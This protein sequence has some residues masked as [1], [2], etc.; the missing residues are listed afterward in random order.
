MISVS[1]VLLQK[2]N[3]TSR[4]FEA[5]LEDFSE[6]V[7]SFAISKGTFNFPFSPN[8]LTMGA[9]SSASISCDV[10]TDKLGK[11]QRVKLFVKI[12]G[13]NQTI[14]LGEYKIT[15][16]KKIP[17]SNEKIQRIVAY[18]KINFLAQK[19]YSS[20][21]KKTI[22]KVWEE[23]CLGSISTGFARAYKEYTGIFAN[24][25]ID[26]GLLSGYNTRDAMSFLA[27]CVGCNVVVNNVG[28]YELREV[29]FFD[30][31]KGLNF[32]RI[33]TPTIDESDITIDYI[34]AKKSNEET[35]SAGDTTGQ[36]LV[37]SNPVLTQ[38]ILN[39]VY[40]SIV[41][42][43]QAYRSGDINYVLADPTVECGDA[44]PLYDN[45]NKKISFVIANE[46]KYTFDGGLSCSI[47]SS[48]PN[49]NESLTLAEKINF[50]VKDSVDS[51]K[52]AQAAIDFSKAMSNGLGMHVSTRTDSTGA[53]IYYLHDK[54]DLEK[55]ERI[56]MVTSEG[57]G[58]A[59][60]WDGDF[61]TGVNAD[62]NIITNMLTVYKINA[63]MIDAGAI[64]STKIRG[65]AVTADKI[66]VED[67]SALNATI[68]NWTIHSNLLYVPSEKQS[69]ATYSYGIGLSNTVV[70]FYAGYLS[71]D[72]TY[73]PSASHPGSPYELGDFDTNKLNFYVTRAGRLVAR[74]AEIS[75][76]ITSVSSD[77]KGKIVIDNGGFECYS[78]PNEYSGLLR[79]GL[80]K[81][82]I[83][84][85]ISTTIPAMCIQSDY[86]NSSGIILSANKNAWQAI[87]NNE[88][89]EGIFSFWNKF[90]GSVKFQ[91]EIWVDG[92]VTTSWFYAAHGTSRYT[93]FRIANNGVLQIG[94]NNQPG[95]TQIY[96]NSASGFVASM[97]DFY[98]NKSKGI[99]FSD[100]TNYNRTFYF[101]TVNDLTGF[102]IGMDSQKNYFYGGGIYEGISGSPLLTIESDALVL[103]ERT[104]NRTRNKID[105]VA[106]TIR[107]R[108]NFLLTSGYKL[109]LYIDSQIYDCLKYGNVELT[110]GTYTG[111][112]FGLDSQPLNLWYTSAYLH[113][114]VSVSGDV[115]V[116]KYI[117]SN[118]AIVYGSIL[119]KVL[120]IYTSNGETYYNVVGFLSND[121]FQ[122]GSSSL[123]KRL[124]L[125]SG[126]EIYCL[127]DFQIAN[128]KSIKVS[129]G[130]TWNIAF[131][132]GADSI[133]K[134]T[135]LQVGVDG[136]NTVLWGT[137][138]LSS[139][140]TVTSDANQKNT[141]ETV[142]DNYEKLFYELKPVTYKYNYGTS[143]RKHLGFIAQDVKNAIDKSDLTT[144]DVAAY[145]SDLCEDGTELLSLR[146]EEFVAL[147][148]H[149]IQKC[150]A[151]ISSLEDEIKL[152][153][154]E[155]INNG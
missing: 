109:Q 82:D 80:V 129:D 20:T 115:N 8:G 21:G 40:N 153:K 86:I 110:S 79:Y 142:S 65:K 50:S 55:S 47:T 27:S 22:A 98:I 121:D 81:A 67:L 18:D 48:K 10:L 51:K 93:A 145:V 95:N 2:I 6:P 85:N 17:G 29:K 108:G 38:T 127:N 49:E 28:R 84:E 133:W 135:G 139:G 69:D 91:S 103:G 75:G 45:N 73:N 41:A 90:Y 140:A 32:D 23:I 92:S 136:K 102:H 42:N 57:I 56:W 134:R 151:K 120:T 13:V 123:P 99:F 88:Q 1:D 154:K 14:Q 97:N 71:D 68:A 149:M 130:S 30:A 11:N 124:R 44:I 118:N 77:G 128:G 144:K 143:D 116:E 131:W 94:A 43:W 35:L 111:L 119:T 15:E 100:G 146:Y 31:Y 25:T 16:A 74:N 60:S 19:V 54:E 7:N 26:S 61:I 4:T 125:V 53:T 62:G 64:T 150:L 147:N 152:L 122:I 37:F 112:H 148:T 83:N 105:L 5:Y 72:D 117:Y 66:K 96:A 101:G 126:S 89:Q 87:Y 106:N 107:C 113:G 24:T 58:F 70:A 34:V 114:Y 12:S 39:N 137:V 52:Y 59:T 9:V 104:E 78:K 76:K 46:I 141:I 33:A 36:G 132:Y 138:M 63:D 3:Q 155:T